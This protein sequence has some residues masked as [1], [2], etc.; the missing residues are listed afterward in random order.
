[1][2]KKIINGNNNDIIN[3]HTKFKN[4]RF[5]YCDFSI[6]N[7]YYAEPILRKIL[8]RMFTIDDNNENAII[9]G[10]NFKLI[11]PI[12]QLQHNNNTYIIPT[13]TKQ[14]IISTNKQDVERFIKKHYLKNNTIQEVIS[15]NPKVTPIHYLNNATYNTTVYKALKYKILLAQLKK[16]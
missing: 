15:T 3:I 13:I 12:Q 1:M 4:S 10:E 2:K 5:Y 11:I 6:K 8:V 14:Y 7:I 16:L 9:V